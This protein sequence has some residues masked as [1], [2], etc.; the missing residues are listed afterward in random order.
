MS[1][2][3]Q[4][5]AAFSHCAPT[6]RQFRESKS[7]NPRHDSRALPH[8]FPHDCAPRSF[9]LDSIYYKYLNLCPLPPSF[10]SFLK[11]TQLISSTLQI[12]PNSNSN[13]TKTS[14]KMQNNN[15][16]WPGHR[17]YFQNAAGQ[18]TDGRNAQVQRAEY[19]NPQ[20]QYGMGGSNT[21]SNGVQYQPPPTMDR[22][23]PPPFMPRNAAWEAGDHSGWRRDM[24]GPGG[25]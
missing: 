19:T 9:S 11:H 14:T 24:G 20:G 16:Q 4:S 25:Y 6:A 15:S 22:Y 3:T 17:A 12:K 10:L 18:W 2:Q 1:A 8:L 13:S 5:Q 7:Q 23:P 21:L